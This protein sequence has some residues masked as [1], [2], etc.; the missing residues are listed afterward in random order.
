MGKRD[1]HSYEDLQ[2]EIKA[3]E[4]HNEADVAVDQL[5]GVE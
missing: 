1:D 4:R 5:G 2:L 3:F